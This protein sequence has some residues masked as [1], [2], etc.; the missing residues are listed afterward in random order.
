MKTVI[1]RRGF[2]FKYSV[3]TASGEFLFNARGM[4]EIRDYYRWE[5]RHGKIEIRKDM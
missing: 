2:K 1:V 3:Y 5:T 4:K